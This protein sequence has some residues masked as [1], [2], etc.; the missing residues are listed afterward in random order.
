M[1]VTLVCL[2]IHLNLQQQQEK[3]LDKGVWMND[4]HK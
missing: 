2:Y 1:S 4:M 3:R